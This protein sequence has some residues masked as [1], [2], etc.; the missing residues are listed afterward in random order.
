MVNILVRL[1]YPNHAVLIR[2]FDVDA[3][4]QEL[5]MILAH[6]T[7]LTKLLKLLGRDKSVAGV[8]GKVRERWREG[9]KRT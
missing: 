5:V 6:S 2:S 8:R 3:I 7:Y 4:Y 9:V 1:F